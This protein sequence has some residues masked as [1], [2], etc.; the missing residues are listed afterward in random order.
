MGALK[1]AREVADWGQ[2]ARWMW[3]GLRNNDLVSIRVDNQIGVMRDHNHLA[4][5]LGSQKQTHQF[6]EDRLWVEAFLGL[7]LLTS[8]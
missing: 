4:F 8:S 7:K 3:P 2:F 5:V 1:A 6:V